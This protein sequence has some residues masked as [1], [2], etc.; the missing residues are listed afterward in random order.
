MGVLARYCKNRNMKWFRARTESEAPTATPVRA[1]GPLTPEL[2]SQVASRHLST[3][4]VAL[5]VGAMRR[6]IRL[7]PRGAQTSVGR[8]GGVAM[9]DQGQDW[10]E[11]AG[12]KLHFV[13]ILDLR[14]VP[15]LPE[16]PLPRDGWLNFFYDAEEQGAWGFDPAQCDARGGSL[17]P[18]LLQ[19]Q[20]SLKPHCQ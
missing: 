20:S 3:P 4:G 6:S 2:V 18:L 10:P 1:K 12:R 14:A 19:N 5:L 17:P 8:L 9:L 16:I 13:A 7:V 15:E 11:W